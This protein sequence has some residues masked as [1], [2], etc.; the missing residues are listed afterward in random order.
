M[1]RQRPAVLRLEDR[2]APSASADFYWADGQKIALTERTGQVAVRFDS[3][4][5]A[6]ALT[7]TGGLLAGYDLV[8]AV[9]PTVVFVTPAASP[10][11]KISE[12]IPLDERPDVAMSAPVFTNPQTG[13]WVVATDQILVRL[14]P[15][16]TIES[17]LQSDD[18]FG[19]STRVVGTPDTYTL[20]L[21]SG[22]GRTALNV[23]NGLMTD[24]RLVWASPNLMIESHLLT[25][26]PLYANEWHLNNTGQSGGTPDADVDA[27]E[28]WQVTTGS[29]N[30]VIADIDDAIQRDHPDL[31]PN[32][33]VN[34]GEIAG[35]GIDDD[36]N[37]WIDDN[38][39]WDFW[40]NDN[41]PSPNAG[42]SDNHGTATAGVAVAA[43]DNGIGVAGIAYG[44]KLMPIRSDIVPALAPADVA[45]AV[46]YAAGRDANGTGTW[47]GAD[48]LT[49]SWAFDAPLQA[50]SDSFAWASAN[51]RGGKGLP[52]FIAAGNGGNN[53][54]A[55]PANL[56][57]T[58]SG[59]MAV[60][61]SS[62]TDVRVSY[63]E[64]GP[65]LDFLTPTRSGDGSGG[66]YTTDRTG[67]DGYSS[68]DYTSTFSG[69]SS[70]TPLAAGIGALVLSRNPNLTAVQVRGLLHN[71][72]D[73]IGPLSYDPSTGKNIEYG[74]GRLNAS[75]AVRGVGVAEI[76]VLNG[77]AD[78]PNNSTSSGFAAAIGANVTRTYRIRNQGTLDLN[79]SALNITTGPFS[80]A[81]GFSDN[82][83][84][85]GEAATFTVKF[86]PT[87]GGTFNRDL[88]FTSNDA[89]EGSFVIH[90]SG[91]APMP[92]QVTSIVVN[93][94]AAQRSAVTTLTVT[95]DRVVTLPSP[96]ANAFTVT[97]P[98][99]NVSITANS[100]TIGGVTVATI[101]FLSPLN[102]GD[103][104][105]RVLGSQIS[106][107]G[108]NLDGDG[109]AVPGGDAVLGFY[110]LF[111][112]ANGDRQV[113]VADLTQFAASFGLISGQAGYAPYFDANGDNSVD[114]V[115][116]NQFGMRFGTVLP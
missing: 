62:N 109:D 21:K 5:D 84:S 90:L 24:P 111:G 15:G 20:D 49:C 60:G 3:P 61:G 52:I 16:V 47:R 103:Y 38:R 48:I 75:T 78:V 85:V 82:V 36:G 102:D 104:T 46:Y 32:V 51:G 9:D 83:L 11:P 70:A 39:G 101:T 42:S 33:W 1:S 88:T 77:N 59:V 44:C 65:E 79:L 22:S 2:L 55:Y 96:N 64:Y 18:R 93:N 105:L 10:R 69:T 73:L 80:I 27:P 100:A 63:S 68:T 50:L 26:D 97:G 114:V 30:I 106:A 91:T 14:Q 57:G 98:A 89:D 25:N 54:I 81:S 58:L 53:S 92:P 113:D 87:A 37:G 4:H 7:R 31:A 23:A 29:P 41:D 40:D 56:A 71:T 76:Q 67:S 13:G 112:D 17:F 34:P 45:S 72:T 107:G 74:F 94:G 86:A 6:A 115:D 35:N 12:T 99:G 19:G 28:A 66:I 43:G 95:F 108:V 116:L 8:Q 110:R